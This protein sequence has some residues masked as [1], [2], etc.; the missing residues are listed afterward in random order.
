MDLLER[1]AL[2]HNQDLPRGKHWAFSFMTEE[3]WENL[4]QPSLVLAGSLLPSGHADAPV[5]VL[6]N[7][8]IKGPAFLLDL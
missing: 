5:S 1:T 3:V 8:P 4:S 7:Q 2:N 6:S